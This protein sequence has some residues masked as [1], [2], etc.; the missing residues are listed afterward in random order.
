MSTLRVSGP[1]FPTLVPTLRVPGP[2]FPT[3]VSTLGVSG[4]R[5]PTLVSTLRV[6]GPP[7]PTLVSTLGVSGPRFPTLGSRCRT[8]VSLSRAL[9]ARYRWHGAR[10]R[11]SGTGPRVR[12]PA[13]ASREQHERAVRQLTGSRSRARERDHGRARRAHRD[14]HA[15]AELERGAEWD[16][17]G[18]VVFDELE[19]SQSHVLINQMAE[20]FVRTANGRLR[21]SRILPE[22]LFVH[23]ELTSLVQVADIAVYVIS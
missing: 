16:E 19:K 21:A 7:F 14:E 9:G 8:S 13:T 22:P 10:C 2:P 20:Y 3:L 23:G 4:P 11:R 17:G 15:G 18:I 5:F 12:D 6:P 1:P